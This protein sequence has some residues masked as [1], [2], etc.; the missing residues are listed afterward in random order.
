MIR[1]DDRRSS[2]CLACADLDHLWFLPSGD[3]TLTRRA[4]SAS[5]LAAT[6]V[7]WSATRRRYE[8]QGTLAEE[9]A[10]QQAEQACLS[11]ADQREARRQRAAER[12]ERLDQEYVAAFARAIRDRYPH[13]PEGAERTIAER[14]CERSSGR[15][16]RTAFAKRLD[17]EAIDLAVRAHVRHQFTRYDDLLMDSDDRDLA[18][19]LVR[20]EVEA[21]LATWRGGA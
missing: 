1:L 16:G 18:R 12:Q 8:R 20:R 15:V 2:R 11:D 19:G 17:P 5:T 4:T 14:A 3:A 9:V 13:C 21:V 6:V 10:L 7:R